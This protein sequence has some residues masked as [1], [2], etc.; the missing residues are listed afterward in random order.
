MR[1]IE[2][3]N[4]QDLKDSGKS[5][6][7]IQEAFKDVQCDLISTKPQPALETYGRALAFSCKTD[8]GPDSSWT[9]IEGPNGSFLAVALD[10]TDAMER[11]QNKTR[12]VPH[13]EQ[14]QRANT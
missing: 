3:I 14:S 1:K 7:Q 4:K 10:R 5:F 2:Q 11:I 13:Q 6:E 8:S 9:L 12:A